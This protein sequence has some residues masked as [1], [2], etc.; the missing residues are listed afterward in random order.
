MG[1]QFEQGKSYWLPLSQVN[2]EAFRLREKIGGQEFEELKKS[3]AEQGQLQP[4]AI[5]VFYGTNTDARVALLIGHRRYQAA[6]EL[7]WEKIWCTPIFGAGDFADQAK[8]LVE[9][10]QRKNL[11]PLEEARAIQKL[12]EKIS[13]SFSN[14]SV[15]PDSQPP[16]PNSQPPTCFSYAG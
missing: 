1:E 8:A 2:A 12:T 4:V 11:A 15:S 10:I 16:T 9:N 6:K 13:F 3:M 7:G 5:L 14:P